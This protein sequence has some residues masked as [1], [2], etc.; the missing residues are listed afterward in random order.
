MCGFWGYEFLW[1]RLI[2]VFLK[3]IF[4]LEY[5]GENFDNNFFFIIWE[6]DLF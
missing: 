1:I 6:E 5:R 3:I 2:K 4:K